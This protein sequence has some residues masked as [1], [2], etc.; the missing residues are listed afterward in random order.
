MRYQH[1]RTFKE[2]A[3]R[4][5]NV[6]ETN[7]HQPKP[8]SLIP[9]LPTDLYADAPNP[10]RKTNVKNHSSL[11]FGDPRKRAMIT[12]N[13]GMCKVQ[14][15]TPPP[16]ELVNG[17]KDLSKEERKH[18]YATAVRYV[19]MGNIKPLIDAFKHK[20][21]CKTG[22]PTQLSRTF[23]WFDLDNS[24]DIDVDE[25]CQAMVFFGLNFTDM[26]V[27]ALF[28]IYDNSLNGSLEYYE[29][30]QKVMADVYNASEIDNTLQRLLSHAEK[31][32]QG[33]SAD[34]MEPFL[35]AGFIQLS[36]EG[37]AERVPEQLYDRF[38][39]PHTG[40][41]PYCKMEELMSYLEPADCPD[42]ETSIQ[43]YENGSSL[44]SDQFWEWWQFYVAQFHNNRHDDDAFIDDS[45]EASP[46]S[47]QHSRR[48]LG[49]TEADADWEAQRDLS[50]DLGEDQARDCANNNNP[51]GVLK[52]PM[53]PKAPAS[54]PPQQSWR[55][56]QPAAPASNSRPMTA[57]FASE[58]KKVQLST[59]FEE[60]QNR[61]KSWATQKPQT[62]QTARAPTGGFVDRLRGDLRSRPST[63]NPYG[64]PK[65]PLYGENSVLCR[66]NTA[67]TRTMPVW[68]SASWAKMKYN[69]P[70]A[71]AGPPSTAEKTVTNAYGQTLTE[72][73]YS[74]YTKEVSPSR[75]NTANIGRAALG[76]Q[77]TWAGAQV[78]RVTD[79][80]DGKVPLSRPSTACP[81]GYKL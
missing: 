19:G 14:R 81:T 55:A 13:V 24:G 76:G 48:R 11:P 67:G 58:K 62:P 72:T 2:D 3:T 53:P 36:K 15:P 79:T 45:L 34:L 78:R 1:S 30:V 56:N 52:K 60:A 32:E 68:K 73:Q 4:A 35:T 80:K 38:K 27:L 66:P 22:G 39:D 43:E 42:P 31:R 5:F 50:L 25:F 17:W 65:S 57:R 59:P 44:S 70:P 54:R 64:A 23:K 77:V 37:K 75:P 47:W 9:F 10:R 26:Q 16:R 21:M 41:L 40:L 63:S 8:D 49:H 20:I 46:T 29:F 12:T 33:Q 7:Q 51:I 69:G 28:A 61:H 6:A 71:T 74:S 18:A